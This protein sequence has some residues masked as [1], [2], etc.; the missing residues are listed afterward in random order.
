MWNTT[1]LKKTFKLTKLF[2][3]LNEKYYKNRLGDCKIE[4]VPNPGN[5]KSAAAAIIYHKKWTGGNTATVYFNS[6]IDWDEKTIRQVLLHEMI[7]YYIFVVTGR[8]LFFSH[9]LHFVLVMLKINLLYN[10]HIHIF[11]AQEESDQGRRKSPEWSTNA[12]FPV[13]IALFAENI[14]TSRL[15]AKLTANQQNNNFKN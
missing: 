11:F 9:G 10:E 8:K 7:H 4:A 13:I 1:T 12:F 6:R 5:N 15:S 14:R 2:R 3:E